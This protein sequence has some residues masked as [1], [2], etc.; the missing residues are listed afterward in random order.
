MGFGVETLEWAEDSLELSEI[1]P[2][3][4]GAGLLLGS[5]ED[6]GV[7]RAE[8]D[9]EPDVALPARLLSGVLD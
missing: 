2:R 4:L 5:R 6:E 9:P 1:I 3:R 7:V 8:E